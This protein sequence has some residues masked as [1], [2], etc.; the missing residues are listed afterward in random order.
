MA[1]LPSEQARGLCD[2]LLVVVGCV[3]PEGR[4]TVGIGWCCVRYADDDFHGGAARHA[5][6]GAVSP[7]PSPQQLAPAGQPGKRVAQPADQ[8][9]D[10]ALN[11]PHQRQRRVDD[12][13][14][15]VDHPVNECQRGVQRRQETLQRGAQLLH[16]GRGLLRQADDVVQPVAGQLLAAGGQRL[17][18]RLVQLGVGIV[19][20]VWLQVLA[21]FHEHHF[22][23][24]DAADEIRIAH[25]GLGLQ[26]AQQPAMVGVVQL[27]RAWGFQI[28]QQQLQVLLGRGA[29]E[30]RGD[31]VHP[32]RAAQV[33][34]IGDVPVRVFVQH[35]APAHLRACALEI[36]R[37]A[38]PA[39][40]D[41]VGFGRHQLGPCMVRPT[42]YAILGFAGVA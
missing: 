18:R 26:L 34:A 30:Q 41:R 9:L 31:A 15:G 7:A 33:L 11:A 20:G 22:H 16:H 19:R 5:G 6:K 17:V 10:A 29:D 37:P 21:S 28:I 1:G 36:E 27:A 14:H 12:A 42:W 25:S 8:R 4:R 2:W 39:A 38:A 24:G 23:L 35:V 3:T 40:I 32:R 13:L